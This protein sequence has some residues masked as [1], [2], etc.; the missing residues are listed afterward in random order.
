M[1]DGE[2]AADGQD[3]EQ[4]WPMGAV[5]RRTGIG[6]HT[7][8]AWER[9]FGFPQPRRLPSGHRRYTSDQVRQLL[10]INTALANGYRA[11]DVVPLERSQLERLLEECGIF[12]EPRGPQ[13]EVWLEQALETCRQLDREALRAVLQHD[14]ATLGVPAYLRTR[15]E[16][17]L[18]GVGEAWRRGELE[19]RHEHFCSEVLEDQ[20]RALRSSLEGGSH[21]RP[22]VLA[23]LPGEAHHL[24]L[25]VAAL[26]ITALD[27][28]VRV[29]G[30]NL[31]P[32]EI[33][34]AAVAVDAAAVGL[35]VSVC[36]EEAAAVE[37]VAT[38]RRL[39]PG[40][41]QLWLGGRGS[42]LLS[43]P[44]TGVTVMPALDDLDG[45]VAALPA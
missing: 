5:T 28:A 40:S 22:V 4:L 16:P 42:T 25:H 21:G 31:P 43:S 19:V 8:R 12:A 29:L 3:L 37:Q 41:V 13:G 38:L 6:E 34:A 32:A 11:G 9:R 26:E 35:S 10:L 2:R 36:L 30:P 20:L 14:A 45:A 39:L 44:P 17:L 33:A 24:G 27:R 23:C 15:V 18:A 7:L 1:N